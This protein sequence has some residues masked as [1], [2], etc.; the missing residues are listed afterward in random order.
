MKNLTYHFQSDAEFEHA[1]QIATFDEFC[2]FA[3]RR[4]LCACYLKRFFELDKARRKLYCYFITY[5][6]DPQKLD[7]FDEAKAYVDSRIN[8]E[9]VTRT[10]TVVEHPDE[11]V[12]FHQILYSTKPLQKSIHF[13]HYMT[14]F[15]FVDFKPA[16]PKND[17]KMV[18]YIT[19]EGKPYTL[20]KP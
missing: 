6:I 9:Y 1:V 16:N 4:T 2:D 5:T 15:G 17:Q 11:N 20:I 18:D 12:H 8:L 7:L 14:K 3:K 10:T 19:K 13:K